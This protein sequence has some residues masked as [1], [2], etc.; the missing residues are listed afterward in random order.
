MTQKEQELLLTVARLFRAKMAQKFPQTPEQKDDLALLDE[1]LSPF[2][3]RR[4]PPI[5]E[6]G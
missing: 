2:Q 5:N 4:A 3:P 6:E 1:A